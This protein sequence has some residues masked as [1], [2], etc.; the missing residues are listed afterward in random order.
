MLTEDK[1]RIIAAALKYIATE[2]ETNNCYELYETLAYFRFAEE[3]IDAE[4][5]R[6]LAEE[7]EMEEWLL[8]GAK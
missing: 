3:E 6:Q 2:I 4:M 8:A 5:L 7:F 1:C